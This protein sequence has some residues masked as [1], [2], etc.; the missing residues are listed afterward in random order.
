MVLSEHRHLRAGSATS[1]GAVTN[2]VRC[3]VRTRAA[4]LARST[5]EHGLSS[6]RGWQGCRRVG[7]F[8]KTPLFMQKACQC[9][10]LLE[11]CGAPG[12]AS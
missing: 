6:R 8:L 9:P 5:C 11:G 7:R 1:E 4:M 3:E 12:D 2:P 10:G